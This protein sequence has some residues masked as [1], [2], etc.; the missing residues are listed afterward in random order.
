[1]NAFQKNKKPPTS[2]VV[3]L[4]ITLLPILAWPALMLHFSDPS[5]SNGNWI[6]MVLFPIYAMLS[7]Y[8]AYRIYYDL[9]GLAW[10][11]II[12]IWLSFAAELILL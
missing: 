10:I 6:I 8:L 1:M 9:K 3:A 4:A 2:F 7:A 5:E 11:L 12:L